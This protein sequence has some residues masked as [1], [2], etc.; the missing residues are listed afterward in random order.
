MLI[1]GGPP[2][3]G[4]NMD[5]F[6]CGNTALYIPFKF[7]SLPSSKEKKQ[8]HFQSKVVE[9]EDGVLSVEQPEGGI[10]HS[11]MSEAVEEAK[12]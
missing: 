12:K 3:I 5:C 4:E 7:L 10:A 8:Q 11:A 9:G 1:R 6:V 2:S